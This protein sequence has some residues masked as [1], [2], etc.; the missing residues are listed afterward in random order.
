MQRVTAV[1]YYHNLFT[2]VFLLNAA[3]IDES[4]AIKTISIFFNLF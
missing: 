3:E 1:D 2:K 4:N